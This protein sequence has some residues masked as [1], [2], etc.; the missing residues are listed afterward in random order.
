MEIQVIIKNN[1]GNRAIYQAC[2]NAELLASIAGTVTLT[3]E[4][5][6]KIK[7]LGYTVS[8]KPNEPSTL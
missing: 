7:N 1:Y 4:V 8:V 2:D 5:I 6:S 3:D